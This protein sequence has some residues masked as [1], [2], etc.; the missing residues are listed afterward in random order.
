MYLKIL[1]L[2]YF[3]K[4]DILVGQ[5]NFAN[6]N[7][8]QQISTLSEGQKMK[9]KMIEVLLFNPTILLDKLNNNLYIHCKMSSIVF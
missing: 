8:Y 7:P 5:L 3:Y 4:I 2:T 9:L 6:F 1:Y